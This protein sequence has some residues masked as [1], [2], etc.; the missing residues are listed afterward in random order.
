MRKKIV[1]IILL[2]LWASLIFYLSDQPRVV[3]N[4]M[5]SDIIKHTLF[6]NDVVLKI[7]HNPLR[8]A[9]HAFEYFIFGLLLINVLKQFNIKRIITFTI[10]IAIIFMVSDEIHQIYVPGRAFEILDL[11]LDFVGIIIACLLH[12]NYLSCMQSNKSII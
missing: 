5:S 4:K 8:E 10:I 1:S 6:V 11:F 12:F 2:L 7:I 9:M 3:S